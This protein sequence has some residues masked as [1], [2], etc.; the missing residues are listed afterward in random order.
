[1][2]A[3]GLKTRYLLDAPSVLLNN[4]TQP[5]QYCLP[6]F[7]EAAS[8]VESTRLPEPR[9]GLEKMGG[10]FERDTDRYAS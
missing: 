6:G 2:Q 8:G 1:M 3:P 9:N 4:K 10:N 7:Q 5:W